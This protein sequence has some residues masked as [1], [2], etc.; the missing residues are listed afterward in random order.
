MKKNALMTLPQKSR[1]LSRLERNNNLFS[2]FFMAPSIFYMIVWTV[3]PILVAFVLSFTNYD[4][5]KHNITNL[6]NTGIS[7]VGLHNYSIAIINPIFQRSLW[8]TIYFALG[9]VVLSTFAGLILAVIA[10]SAKGKGFFRVAYYVPC[11]TTTSSLIIIFDGIFRPNTIITDF[12]SLFGMP[13]VIWRTSVQ[14][15]MPLAILMCI[16]AGAGFNML[17]YLAGL[18]GIPD[19]VYEAAKLDGASRSQQF[20][21]ITVPL[22]NNQTF[23]LMATGFIGSLQV[24][25]IVQILADFGEAPMTGGPGGSLWTAVYYIYNVGWTQNKMGRA[26]AISFLLL[27]FI[28]IFTLIQRLIFKDQTN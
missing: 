23:F 20:W 14:L 11:I 6:A 21:H 1:H 3:F 28:A 17:I 12:L 25:N 9:T 8:Q 18:Q 27:I 7:F 19:T 15:D 4:M 5:L 22:V 10:N 24:F 26:S 16:W 2:Y 13:E